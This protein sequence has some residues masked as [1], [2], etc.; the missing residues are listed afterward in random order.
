MKSSVSAH[1][2]RS[3]L[4]T[5]RTVT[6]AAPAC[7]SA[8]AADWTLPP[9]TQ[10]SSINN[11]CFASTAGATKFPALNARRS[12]TVGDAVSGTYRIP[13]SAGQPTSN[14]LNVPRAG[15]NCSTT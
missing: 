11:T 15:A 9:L 3:H 5:E 2:G 7:F 4:A 6:F 10:V 13:R 14:R 8:L 1:S 12:A